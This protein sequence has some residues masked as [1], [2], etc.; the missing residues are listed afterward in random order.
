L[1]FTYSLFLVGIISI[2][3][4]LTIPAL[5]RRYKV[6]STIQV[7]PTPIGTILSQDSEIQ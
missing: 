6:D 7:A 2:Y 5:P 3:R 4:V 1:M